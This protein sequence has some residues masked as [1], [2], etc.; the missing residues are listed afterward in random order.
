MKKIII[1]VMVSAL[2]LFALDIKTT[3]K[4]KALDADWLVFFEND[5]DSLQRDSIGQVVSDRITDSLNQT[6][7]IFTGDI[8]VK[9]NDLYFGNSVII[10][11]TAAGVFKIDADS[12]NVDTLAVNGKLTVYDLLNIADNDSITTP[13]E[14]DVF[15][16]AVLHV[17]K[18][19]DGTSWQKLW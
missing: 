11:N 3:E 13:I 10:Q 8:K 16:D 2:F 4:V 9:G 5:L 15:Y 1:A 17:L 14:G 7:V 6:L 12:T 19:W 18:C